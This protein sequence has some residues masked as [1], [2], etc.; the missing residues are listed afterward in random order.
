[1]GPQRVL[2]LLVAGLAVLGGAIW[3]ASTRHLERATLTG[4]L[5]LPGLEQG[6]NAVTEVDL[7]KGDGTRTSLKRDSNA[8]TVAER[9][10]PADTTKVRKLLLD[11]GALTVV[12]EKTRLP[13]NY[14]Q[15]GVEDV[16]APKASGTRIDAISPG[17]SWALI[18]GKSSSGKSGY[19]RVASAQQSLLAAPLLMVDAS[20]ASWL[21]RVLLDV[22]A[23]RVREIEEHP[24]KGDAYT[25]TRLKQ[26]E[27]NFSVSPLPKDR[28][29]TGP[30]VAEAIAASLG[31]L[32][33][34]D[35]HKVDSGAT[36]TAHATFRT[37]DGL[38]LAL[39]GRQD[40]DH[41]LIAASAQGSTPQGQAEAQ[42]LNARL[43][44]FEFEIPQYRY[45]V[46]FK[47]LLELLTVPPAPAKKVAAGKPAAKPNPLSR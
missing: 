24:A 25:A 21:D 19:V 18:V 43:G 44:G 28:A 35:V 14:P 5:V 37:Y 39:S 6:V 29:L 42:K 27:P 12:E 30:S 23:E 32:T 7:K 26:G 4:D 34:D 9:S 1:M 47:P 11:L 41:Y 20:P 8:W 45:D 13:A 36:A 22:G 31:A 33:L 38:E 16:S 10:W 15:L 2:V 46:I 40:G 17:K 3:L